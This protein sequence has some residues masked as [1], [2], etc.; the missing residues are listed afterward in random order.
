MT[1]GFR[2]GGPDTGRC[3]LL[4][5]RKSKPG[6][7]S[8]YNDLNQVVGDQRGAATGWA[9]AKTVTGPPAAAPGQS[10]CKG[11]NTHTPLC[12]PL[13]L[14]YSSLMGNC[15]FPSPAA[16]GFASLLICCAQK[17]LSRS[18]FPNLLIKTTITALAQQ[19][20]RFV[21]ASVWD[22]VLRLG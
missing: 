18:S 21:D 16:Q 13:I 9:R 4:P 3:L 20:E 1:T 22:L 11:E 19:F 6:G 14:E 10:L 5:L 7:G 12:L 17:P 8:R 2:S 15:H